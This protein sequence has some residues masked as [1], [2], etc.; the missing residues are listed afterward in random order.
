MTSAVP[1]VA[2][3]SAAM[4]K[5]C[6][7]EG[8]GAKKRE[9]VKPV[10]ALQYNRIDDCFVGDDSGFGSGLLANPAGSTLAL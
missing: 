2:V 6:Q 8:A 7:S 9:D 10:Y 4:S 1:A 3:I 5:P